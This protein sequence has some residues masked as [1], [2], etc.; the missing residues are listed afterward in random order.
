MDTKT[1]RRKSRKSEAPTA[2]SF[3]I[4]EEDVVFEEK[5]DV[6]VI[7]RIRSKK[8]IIFGLLAVLVFTGVICAIALCTAPSTK[9]KTESTNNDILAPSSN[10]TNRTYDSSSGSGDV[11]GIKTIEVNV[12]S[13]NSSFLNTTVTFTNLTTQTPTTGKTIPTTT[14][15]VTP[16]SP[17]TAPVAA[18]MVLTTAPTPRTPT[19][20]PT[21]SPTLA[22][23]SAPTATPT[24]QSKVNDNGSGLWGGKLQFVNNLPQVCIY[25]IKTVTWFSGNGMGDLVTGATVTIGPFSGFYTLGAQENVF[26]DCAYAGTCAWNNKSADNYC[27]NFSVTSGCSVVYHDCPYPPGQNGGLSPAPDGRKRYTVWGSVDNNG[28]CVLSINHTGEG[29]Y[30]CSATLN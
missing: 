30:Y 12:T 23:T 11:E 27:Y 29:P 16:T 8:R 18:Q 3:I 6:E 19:P 22:P 26:A 13:R 2:S 28:V 14:P 7:Q 24:Q 5:D 25:T 9:A 17:T 4:H 15:K 21:V 20:T 10:N 1:T